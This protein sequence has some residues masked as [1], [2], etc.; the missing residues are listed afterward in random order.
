MRNIQLLP[1][2][3]DVLTRWLLAYNFQAEMDKYPNL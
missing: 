1:G 3:A 2:A